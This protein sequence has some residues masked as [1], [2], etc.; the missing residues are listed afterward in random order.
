MY[1]RFFRSG[2]RTVL[3]DLCHEGGEILHDVRFGSEA[4][5]LSGNSMSALPPKAD[6]NSHRL[7]RL[8]CANSRHLLTIGFSVVHLFGEVANWARGRNVVTVAQLLADYLYEN[9]SNRNSPI[10]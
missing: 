9:I 3:A 5:I 6:I 10:D 2:I 4:D 1:R 8:L 7:E